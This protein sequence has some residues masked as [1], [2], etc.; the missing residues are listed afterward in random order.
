MKKIT[1]VISIA[2]LGL[3][4]ASCKKK[5]CTDPEAINYEDKVISNNLLCQYQGSV[6]FWYDQ[7]KMDSLKKIYPIKSLEYFVNDIR[8]D[9]LPFSE[10]LDKRPTSCSKKGIATF[11]D[12]MDTGFQQYIK[13]HIQTDLGTILYDSIIQ[14]TANQC[15]KVKFD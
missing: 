2:L 4:F 6:V 8:I 5:G 10:P 1:L 9:S 7:I 13:F 3:S 11:A 12:S 15:L 14:M